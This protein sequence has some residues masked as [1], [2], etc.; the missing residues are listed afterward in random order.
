MTARY[1]PGLIIFIALIIGGAYSY[2]VESS[3]IN[4]MTITSGEVVA[5]GNRSISTRT[6][7][8]IEKTVDTQAI[9]YFKVNNETYRVEGRAMGYPYW[10]LG[11]G[12]EVYFAKDNPKQTRINRWDE[13]YFFTL[14]CSFFISTTILFSIINFIAYKLRGR[15]L[16]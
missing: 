11:Q 6:S 3:Y 14:T 10:E 9:V 4:G 5:F 7:N 1:I 8:D 12:V 2:H 13:I 16:L 15:P